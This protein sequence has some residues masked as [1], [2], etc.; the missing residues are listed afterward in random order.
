M[1]TEEHIQRAAKLIAERDK[2]NR[3]MSAINANPK[4]TA[5]LYVP[6]GPLM[7]GKGECQALVSARRESV[8]H[9]LGAILRG[10]GN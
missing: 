9:E 1:L 4:V 5:Q 3:I 10:N 2:L 7:L 8:M 6:N